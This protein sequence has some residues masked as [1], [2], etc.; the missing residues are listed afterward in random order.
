MDVKQRQNR[1]EERRQ[2]RPVVID[3]NQL[4]SVKEAA[5]ARDMAPSTLM[6]HIAAGRVQACR[7][8][9]RVKVLG[10]EI[11]RMNREVTQPTAAAAPAASQ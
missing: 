11:I 4:Y 1:A 9:F 10:A 3:A 2:N 8:G 7:D 6:R 5:A